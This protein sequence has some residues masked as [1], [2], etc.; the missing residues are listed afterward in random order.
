MIPPNSSEPNIMVCSNIRSLS[1]NHR[2]SAGYANAA[3]SNLLPYDYMQTVDDWSMPPLQTNTL[4]KPSAPALAMYCLVG[5]KATSKMLSSNFLRCAVISW[6]HVLLSKFHN[7]I[8]QSCE[9]A[10]KTG[11]IEIDYFITA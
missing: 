10:N 2:K 3:D 8:E 6:T 7:L 5:W 11:V 4:A 9:P 1:L